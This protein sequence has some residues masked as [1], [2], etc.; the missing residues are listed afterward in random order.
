MIGI[1]HLDTSERNVADCQIEAVVFQSRVLKAAVLDCDIFSA[2]RKVLR[3]L[4]CCAV[5]F[6]TNHTGIADAVRHPRYKVACSAGRFENSGITR[7]IHLLDCLIHCVND[8]LRRIVCGHSAC[9]CRS[10]FLR[11]QVLFQIAAIRGKSFKGFI[12]DLRYAAPTGVCTQT[13]VGVFFAVIVLCT[14]FI[15]RSSGFFVFFQTSDF[16]NC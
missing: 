5:K 3:N 8:Y 16:P 2:S 14:F 6:D 1:E 13:P 4:C 12:E 9:S 10:I 7:E 15:Q 11:S